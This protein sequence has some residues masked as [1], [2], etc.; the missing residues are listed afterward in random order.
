MVSSRGLVHEANDVAILEVANWS[1]HVDTWL[2]PA[3]SDNPAV[4]CIFVEIACHLLLVGADRVR[5]WVRVQEAASPAH[6][7]Q[8]HL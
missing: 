8:R 1:I 2:L 3:H 7:F 5:L 4:I 6:I